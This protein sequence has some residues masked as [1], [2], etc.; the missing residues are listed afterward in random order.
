MA[1]KQALAIAAAALIAPTAAAEAAAAGAA[2]ASAPAPADPSAA[3]RGAS[4]ASS[5]VRCTA[6][7]AYDCRGNPTCCQAGFTCYEKDQHWAACRDQR[8]TPGG[9]MQG[10]IDG[11]PWTCR[12]LGGPHEQPAPPALPSTSSKPV[13]PPSPALPPTPSPAPPPCED[14]SEHCTA[15]AAQNECEANPGYMHTMCQKSC[16]LC[17]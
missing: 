7:Y 9:A 6:S 13:L 15:W 16:S 8:C 14:K 17:Q 11:R 1:L 4:G 10:D 2:S 5:A 3:L 12:V